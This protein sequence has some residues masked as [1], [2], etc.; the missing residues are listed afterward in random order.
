MENFIIIAI[1]LTIVISISV[2]LHRAKKE[3]QHCIGCPYS[4]KCSGACC[5]SDDNS[6]AVKNMIGKADI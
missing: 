3:G 2:Y 1:V 4:K 5:S 6:A